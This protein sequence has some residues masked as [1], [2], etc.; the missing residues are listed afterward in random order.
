[1][2]VCICV[3]V[4]GIEYYDG[5]ICMQDLMSLCVVLQIYGVVCDGL[6]QIVQVIDE[7][8]CSVIDNLLIG[9]D[10]EQLQVY[11]QVYVVGLGMGFVMDQFVILVV[12]IVVMLEWCIDWLVNLLVSGLFVFLF[13]ESGV[14]LGFMIV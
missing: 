13:V 8:L 12:Q 6:V 3:V 7:E 1:M 14:G 9:G 4:V 2:V 5:I 10:I 11:F